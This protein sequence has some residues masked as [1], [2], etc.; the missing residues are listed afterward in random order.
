M[1]DPVQ[2]AATR[3][4]LRDATFQERLQSSS[5]LPIMKAA[6]QEV[7][8][9]GYA[10]ALRDVLALEPDGWDDISDFI[11]TKQIQALA[12]KAGER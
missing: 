3:A 6:M 5:A 11:Y 10:A 8:S 7:F 2:D 1:P 4:A 9:E 12:A